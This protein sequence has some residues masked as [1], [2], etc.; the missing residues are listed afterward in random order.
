MVDEPKC[1][2][3]H[4]VFCRWQFYRHGVTANPSSW[5][6]SARNQWN[7]NSKRWRRESRPRE[8]SL[9]GGVC[10]CKP[11]SFFLYVF[12]PWWA[13]VP[14]DPFFSPR[15]T[16]W[17]QPW[18][19]PGRMEETRV[20]YSVR[21]TALK[22]CSVSSSNHCQIFTSTYLAVVRFPPLTYSL[23]CPVC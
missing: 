8:R 1:A 18:A 10:L 19:K 22:W 14:L 5:N 4:L 17:F 23:H 6:A 11:A 2:L 12:L 21:F 16:P 3:C 7:G 9:S 13:G 20:V 15:I